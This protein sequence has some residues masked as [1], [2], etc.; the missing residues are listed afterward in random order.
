LVTSYS[1][2][3]ALLKSSEIDPM[4]RLVLIAIGVEPEYKSVAI[5]LFGWGP[6]GEP[7][8]SI[9]AES[10]VTNF[11]RLLKLI[12]RPDSSMIAIRV[13]PEY[14]CIARSLSRWGS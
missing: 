1:D 2:V 14:R 3:V 4:I 10:K 11:F 6:K 13:E 12:W 5:S 9:A 7:Y 8:A